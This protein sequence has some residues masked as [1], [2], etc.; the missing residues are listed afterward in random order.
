VF[1]TGSVLLAV[2]SGNVSTDMVSEKT[3]KVKTGGCRV[4]DSGFRVYSRFGLGVEDVGS[5][6]PDLGFRIGTC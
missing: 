3:D 2:F 6:I 1:D 4:S 5:R